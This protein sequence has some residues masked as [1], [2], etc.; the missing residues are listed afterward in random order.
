MKRLIAAASLSIA[1]CMTAAPAQA[2]NTEGKVQLKLLG[3]GVLPD[4]KITRVKFDGIGLP[5]NTQTAADDNYVPTI[6]AEYFVARNF[7][8]ETICCVTQHDVTGRGGLA[9]AGLVA[10]A[11]I[12]PATLTAKL[13]VPLAGGI[14]PYFGAGPTYFIFVD[15]KP[16][17]TTRALGATRQ[18]LNDKLGF[19]LQA[20]LDI[21][22]NASGLGISLDA[23][24]YF[25]STDARWFA[26]NRLVLHTRHKLDPWVISAGL[27]YRF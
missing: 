7:S 6:A 20:G 9:G 27:A 10:N 25:V 12:I 1:L 13:H 18:R 5:A 21:P 26:G 16:G 11:N 23:K 24:R 4:G 22:V 2:G 19:A 15:E 17:A 14:K 8:L 3:T